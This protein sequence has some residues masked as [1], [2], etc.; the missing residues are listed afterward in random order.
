MRRKIVFIHELLDGRFNLCYMACRMKT[1]AYYEVYLG[2]SSTLCPLDGFVSILDRLLYVEAM[3]VDF[4]RLRIQIIL[5]E[6]PF[7]G[8]MI[9]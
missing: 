7:C 4:T 8:L 3:E 1:F 5:F 9:K 6:D 2:I